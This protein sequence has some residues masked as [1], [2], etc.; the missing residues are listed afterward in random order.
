MINCLRDPSTELQAGSLH[1]VPFIKTTN[2]ELCKK[3]FFIMIWHGSSI[4]S[5]ILHYQQLMVFSCWKLGALRFRKCIVEKANSVRPLDKN[6][7]CGWVL[8][9]GLCITCSLFLCLSVKLCSVWHSQHDPVIYFRF[10]YVFTF[11]FRIFV[12]GQTS[13]TSSLRLG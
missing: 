5:K 10:V 3:G 7:F 9:L 8:P 4:D 1:S 11:P 2:E 13:E 12:E 6:V